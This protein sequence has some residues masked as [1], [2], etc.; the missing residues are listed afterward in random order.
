M[1]AYKSRSLPAP[2]VSTVD[3]PWSGSITIAVNLRLA[4]SFPV[5]FLWRFFVK[6]SL[7]RPLLSRQTQS[8]SIRLTARGT[9]ERVPLWLFCRSEQ[10]HRFARRWRGCRHL[11]WRIPVQRSGLLTPD[12][13]CRHQ[14]H[15][16]LAP[17][18]VS[19]PS[20]TDIP[21]LVY[22]LAHNTDVI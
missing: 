2:R 6:P 8:S 1:S 15:S 22:G 14:G 18:T 9:R 13:G 20:K 19:A 12:P 16:K 10:I 5:A 4:C 11:F 7:W 17:Q 21:F 3:P